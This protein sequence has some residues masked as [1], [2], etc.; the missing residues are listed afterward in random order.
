MSRNGSWM[1]SRRPLT[2]YPVS[3]AIVAINEDLLKARLSQPTSTVRIISVT[4]VGVRSFGSS[5]WQLLEKRLSEW[6]SAISEV[7]SVVDEAEAL[8]A[9]G[10]I[11][12]RNGRPDGRQQGQGSS[13]PNGQREEIAA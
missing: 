5:E 10:P 2:N 7:K 12:H 3:N 13:Q 1:V 4:S 11:T 6:K 9:S 8:A